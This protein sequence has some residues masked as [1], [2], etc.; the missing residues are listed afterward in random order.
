MSELLNIL[1]SHLALEEPVHVVDVGASPIEGDAPYKELL[2]NGL[3][4]VTGF[5]PQQDALAELNARKSAQ[6]TY[7]PYAMGG[8]EKVKL[9][10]YRH[11]GFTS[12][13]A[14]NEKVIRM[15]GRFRRA[16]RLQKTVD[17]ETKRLD[18]LPEVA[19]IDFLKID[20]QGAEK[21]I[22]ENGP[23]SLKNAVAV[24][25]E[26]RFIPLYEGEPTFGDLDNT[27]KKQGFWIHNFLPIKRVVLSSVYLQKLRNRAG[28][29]I[30]DGDA[31]YVRNL[32]D[33]D[34]LSGLQLKKLAFIACS[35]MQSHDLVLH[36]IDL[37]TQ[38][39]LADKELVPLYMQA[40][41][42]RWVKE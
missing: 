38:R 8:G 3:C 40:L 7:L 41:P 13:F 29:Q 21:L 15:I 2:E 16:T 23:E 24:Q 31:F 32:Y 22:I 14:I 28:R 27:L 30:V 37:L 17:M 1:V 39:G 11:G 12:V 4:R 35:V 9:H 25:T 10:I 5:E 36:C 34:S 6:E 42:E 18:D 33:T 26:V 20:V 19:G